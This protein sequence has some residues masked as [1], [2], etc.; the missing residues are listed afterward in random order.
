MKIKTKHDKI[1]EILFE[2]EFIET[3]KE[4]EV[5]FSQAL[6]LSR[7]IQTEAVYDEVPY[8]PKL[9]KE[10][11]RFNFMSDIDMTSGWGN[12]SYHLLKN[13]SK[14]NIALLGK[15]NGVT[16]RDISKLATKELLRE[17]AM[18]WHD[19]PRDQWLNSPFEKNIAIIPFETTL[20]PKSWVS[21]I[22]RFDVL[23][24]LC[25]QNIQM[26]KD[27][28]VK[29]PI[30]KIHWGI[31][32]DRY[33]EIQRVSNRTF[34]FGTHGALSKRKGT[35]TLVRAFELAFPNNE[36]V[37]LICKTSNYFYPFLSKDKRIKVIAGEKDDQE[38]KDEYF[39]QIDVGVF[40]TRGEGFGLCPLECLSTGVPV[41]MTGWGGVMEYYNPECTTTIDY[42]MVPAEDFT[43]FVYKE[44]CG[45]W[46]DPDLNDLIVKLRYAYEHQDEMKERGKFGAK[47][48]REN[49]GWEDKIKMFHSLL[50]K[51]L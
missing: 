33:P 47:Y 37:R 35:D 21:K 49:W 5:S 51:Y 10:E 7:M 12:A 38:M 23:F 11:K 42:K 25:D 4:I 8:N 48:V 41:I 29:I 28:G 45:D 44:E 30:E 24:T 39:S 34:T 15:L 14:Y 20:V 46:A 1:K 13:S 6:R 40:P 16:D 2:N 18:I 32:K 43:K 3:N 36:D 19:Q 17:G 22:N 27:S 26:F 9:F 50:D 31:E